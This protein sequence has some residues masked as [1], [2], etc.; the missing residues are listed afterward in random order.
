MRLVVCVLVSLLA[1]GCAAPSTVWRFDRLD[2]IGGVK[3]HAVG[4]P[5]IVATGAGPAVRFDGIDD[6]LFVDSHPLAGA[7]TFTAEAV[8]RPEDGP[9]EQRWLHLAEVDPVTGADTGTRFLFEVRVKGG[10]WYLDSFVNGPGYN[11]PLMAPEKSFPIGPWYRVEMSYDG[12][13][14]RSYVDGVLQCQAPIA[15]R[16]QGPGHTSIGT[17]INKVDY[18]R[19]AVLMLRFTPRALRPNEFLALPAGLNPHG[20]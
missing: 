20:N 11:K 4:H 17:R 9:F 1:A 8:F 14:F 16:P 15:F 10:Q 3:V 18:F 13:M 19:G 12:T 6:A 7:A 5:Q 2:E